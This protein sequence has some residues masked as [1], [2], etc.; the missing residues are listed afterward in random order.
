MD[1]PETH[2][3]R[4]ERGAIAYQ[5]FGHGQRTIVWAKPPVIS[6]DTQWE[7]PGHIRLWEFVASLGR[8]VIFDFRG[9][10]ISEHLPLD[11]ISDLEELSF[12]LGSIIEQLASPPTVLVATGAA[13]VAAIALVAARPGVV[14]RL[15][16]LNAAASSPRRDDNSDEMIRVL[17]ERWG[18]GGV[19][20]GAEG[21]PRDARRRQVAAR[22]ERISA[23]PDVLE[24]SVRATL[25]H[26]VRPLLAEVRIPTLVVYTG[27]IMNV[28]AEM[29][30]EVARGIPGCLYF[31]RPSASFNWGEWDAD[32]KRFVTGSDSDVGGQ[33]ELTALLF[34]DV[35]GS[36][37]HAARVGD[38]MWRRTL[39]F[40]DA[41]VQ[42]QVDLGHGRIVKQTGDGHLVEFARPGDALTVARQLLD[43][44]PELGLELR[45]G[46][47]YGEVE[48]RPNGDV[49]GIAVHVAARI[50]A[51]AGPHE[52]LVSR[53][54]AD[55]TVGSGVA[56]SDRG[57]HRLK[58]V[59][60]EW[61]IFEAT[62]R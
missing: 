36:T 49:G 59:P 7:L 26:D 46:V 43:G 35:V 16:L 52:I 21:D 28:T 44:V 54:V 32:I 48:R 19:L 58:G 4:T 25:R 40:L 60:G 31:T 39:D 62:P 61:Q 51:L 15:V 23:T 41:F 10:G 38:A 45:V 9:F 42:R 30:E 17:R 50:A 33:R 34:S 29:T 27:D 57:P 18:T 6:I 8:A 13:S 56:F 14:E 11:R 12:D 55:L 20:T 5:A 24:A 22:T 3:L 53:T 37:D 2:Y 47:H 1:V